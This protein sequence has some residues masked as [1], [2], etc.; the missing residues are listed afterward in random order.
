MCVCGCLFYIFW[1]LFQILCWILSNQVFLLQ[2]YSKKIEN[3]TC[4][5]FSSKLICSL[6][7]VYIFIFNTNQISF[8]LFHFG[9]AR[10]WAKQN[11]FNLNQLFR[12]GLGFCSCNHHFLSRWQRQLELNSFN[13]RESIRKCNHNS[14]DFMLMN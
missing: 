6:F 7:F 5:F 2:I 10:N 1:K 9:L 12:V 4:F 13:E 11:P 8:N 14:S 3:K